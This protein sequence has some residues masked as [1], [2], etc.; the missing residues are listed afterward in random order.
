[1]YTSEA[2]VFYNLRQQWSKDNPRLLNV[3]DVSMCRLFKFLFRIILISLFASPR[4]PAASS[5]KGLS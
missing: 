4:R 2:A 1:M 5:V 3:Y